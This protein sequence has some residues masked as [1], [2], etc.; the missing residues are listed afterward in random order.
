MVHQLDHRYSSRERLPVAD[1]IPDRE[2]T[3]ANVAPHSSINPRQ[4][5][6]FAKDF[7]LTAEFR[8]Y[9]SFPADGL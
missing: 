6:G 5:G 3:F 2:E 1:F 4:S 7:D 8:N 9:K